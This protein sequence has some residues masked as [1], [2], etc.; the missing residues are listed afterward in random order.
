MTAPHEPLGHRP[1]LDG[2]RAVAIVAV[3][4]HHAATVFP[5]EQRL[6]SGGFLGV[7]LF[8]VLSGFLITTL[9]LE[10]RDGDGGG[11]AD[12]GRFYRR[13]AAR[14]LPAL[15]LYLA[16]STIYVAGVGGDLRAQLRSTVAAATFATNWDLPLHLR[17]SHEQFH[18]WS[19][20]L[21]EQFYLLWPVALLALVARSRDPRRPVVAA[22]AVVAGWRLLLVVVGV[23]VVP[24]AFRTDTRIDTLLVGCA[25]ALVERAGWRPRAATLRWAGP[26]ALGL[27]GVAFWSAGSWFRP[28]AAGGYTVVAL[29]AAVLV[30]TAEEGT[31]PLA[32]A[33][34]HPWLVAIGR[35][36]Y[37]LYL[38]HV[39]VFIGV[40]RWLDA[41]F[42]TR[43]A[44]AVALSAAVAS[45]SYRFVERPILAAAAAAGT[46]PGAAARR[47]ASGAR[48]RPPLVIAAFGAATLLLAGTAVAYGVDSPA[49]PAAGVEVAAPTLPGG[50]P[51]PSPPAGPG[52]VP[53]GTVEP[54]TTAP[55]PVTG[56]DGVVTT[57]P[58]E[59]PPTTVDPLGRIAT[60]LE[61]ELPDL[62]PITLGGPDPVELSARLLDV[63]GRPVA[64]ARV[65]LEVVGPVDALGCDADTDTDGVARC[66]VVAGLVPVP[67][68]GVAATF[69]GDERFLG[70]S[71]SR[72]A[73]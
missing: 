45:W 33:L 67:A 14:L 43:T 59:P 71:A 28:L 47:E 27:L 5:H 15:A 49:P 25:L 38:W 62:A 41:G 11:R 42:V 30:A 51:A 8:F 12:L 23:D 17:L 68:T 13:R 16:A 73:Q 65:D 4:W 53:P 24:L 66:E 10:R 20:A 18:L 26:A 22:I 52:E 36:S 61:L 31:S 9:L 6:P 29:L 2:L 46:G 70:S 63:E 48:G 50:G 35:R 32:R 37:S 54:P 57:V 40:V 3:L 39:L 56:E 72:S 7:D 58:V 55:A 34:A 1:A 60:R 21:E 19:L 44:V 69:R 64:G